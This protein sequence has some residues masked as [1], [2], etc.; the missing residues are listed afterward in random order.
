[1][2]LDLDILA[3][4][5][6]MGIDDLLLANPC[7]VSERSVVGIAPKLSDVKADH[8]GSDTGIARV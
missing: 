2:S 6:Y 3:V 4:A 7:W 5:L 8:I 1:M